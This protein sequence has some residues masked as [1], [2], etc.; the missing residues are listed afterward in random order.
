LFVTASKRVRRSG[1]DLKR[2]DK[3]QEKNMASLYTPPEAINA[4][5][6]SDGGRLTLAGAVLCSAGGIGIIVSTI[7]KVI[8]LGIL[9]GPI[10]TLSWLALIVGV[11]CFVLGFNLI[12]DARGRG[13]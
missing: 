3:S 2:S 11:V 9:G 6:R 1:S 10:A 4:R 5:K 7:L 12:K 8:W 13:V